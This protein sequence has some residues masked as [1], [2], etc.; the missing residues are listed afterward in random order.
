MKVYHSYYM[1]INDIQSS[2]ILKT[3]KSSKLKSNSYHCYYTR[4]SWKVICL[5]FVKLGTSGRWVDIIGLELVSPPHLGSVHTFS[6]YRKRRVVSDISLGGSR[7]RVIYRR[8][9]WDKNLVR[10]QFH[11]SVVVAHWFRRRIRR[12][13]KYCVDPYNLTNVHHSS[14][15][16]S[17]ELSQ[18]ESKFRVFYRM[19]PENFIF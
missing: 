4:T 19:N 12:K 10:A 6:T 3:I 18:L 9:M 2:D 16:V 8:D 5:A 7:Q 15:V 13:R 1:C 17:R 14:A 11:T